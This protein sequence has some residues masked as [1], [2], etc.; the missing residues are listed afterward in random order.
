MYSRVC[1]VHVQDMQNL[2]TTVLSID[3]VDIR[4]LPL[5]HESHAEGNVVMTPTAMLSQ[6]HITVP[7]K[8]NEEAAAQIGISNVA[9]LFGLGNS[10]RPAPKN[11]Q[12]AGGIF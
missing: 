11:V 10:M 5:Q 6:Y 9:Q 12:S 4:E 7:Y 8:V 2:S 1:V 3:G